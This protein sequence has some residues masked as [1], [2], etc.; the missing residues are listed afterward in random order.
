MRSQS[1][2][3]M[4]E[5]LVAITLVVLLYVTM[6]DRLLP[7]RG[8]AEAANV[9]TVVGGLRSALG[10]AVADRLVNGEVDGIADLAGA[11]P[12]RLLSEQPENYLGEVSGVAPENLPTGHWYFD[13]ASGELV[14]LVR[15]G[16]YFRTELEGVPRMVFRVE[17]V[18]NDR[19]EIGGVRLHRVN[20]FVWTQSAQLT[21]MLGQPR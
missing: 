12:M 10:L 5:M 17:I 8:D 14:Y 4:L 20:A 6:L 16:D 15:Y 2:F 19:G 1:G 21:E 18:H 11:N 13:G 9:V 7:M 3:T